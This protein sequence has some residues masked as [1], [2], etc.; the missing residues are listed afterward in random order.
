MSAH[1]G[2]QEQTGRRSKLWGFTQSVCVC[3]GGAPFVVP[4]QTGECYLLIDSE[5]GIFGREILGVH[6][7]L[8]YQN[9]CLPGILGKHRLIKQTNLKPSQVFYIP[10]IKPTVWFQ[11]VTPHLSRKQFQTEP[12]TDGCFDLLW[13]F[14]IHGYFCHCRTRLFEGGPITRPSCVALELQKTSCKKEEKQNKRS[15]TL[16]LLQDSTQI[17]KKIRGGAFPAAMPREKRGC[18]K[19]SAGVKGLPTPILPNKS[20]A[21][22]ATFGHKRQPPSTGDRYHIDP[23]LETEYYVFPSLYHKYINYAN[24]EHCILTKTHFLSPFRGSARGAGSGYYIQLTA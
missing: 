21:A 1:G 5:W 12:H 17:A 6:G 13:L 18:V 16:S 19:T 15:W 3:V 22:T 10:R 20:L 9:H 7:S 2:W 14:L 8:H 4:S 23:C 24:Y 11:D